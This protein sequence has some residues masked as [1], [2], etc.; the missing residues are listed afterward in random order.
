MGLRD[1]AKKGVRVAAAIGSGGATEVYRGVT[2]KADPV[3]AKN[4]ELAGKV[5]GYLDGGSGGGGGAP[6][7]E[8]EEERR[9]REEREAA[10]DKDMDVARKYRDKALGEPTPLAREAPQVSAPGAIT[11]VQAAA[12]T[13]IKASFD[14]RDI[15]EGR[16]AYQSYLDDQRAIAAGKTPSAAEIAMRRGIASATAQQFALAGGR[17]GYSTAGLRAA[18]RNAAA[19]T[20]EGI[21]RTGE[22]RAQEMAAAN[23][24]L[25]QAI[26][27]GRGQDITVATTKGQLEMDAARANQAA[28][29]QTT[30][31]NAGWS[32]EAILKMSDQE[33]ATRLANAGYKL[34]QEQIDDLRLKAQRDWQLQAQGQVLSSGQA[35]AGASS[36]REARLQQLRQMQEEAKRRGDAATEQMIATLIATY[37]TSGA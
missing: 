21:S 20:Q 11:P 23:E 12:P 29:L 36:D 1:W 13:P 31:A 4:E 32:N 6:A 30:L 17:G 37:I 5:A 3:T 7:G 35:A 28:Q 15:D 8:T 34:T 19:I 24:R 26:A 14:S 9:R 25:G 27:T 10:V 33:L 22:V 18:G 2:G 16:R